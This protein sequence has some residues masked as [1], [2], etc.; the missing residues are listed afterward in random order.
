MALGFEAATHL[1]YASGRVF[2]STNLGAVA[3]LDAYSGSV[4]WLNIYRDAS[5]T[6][7]PNLMMVGPMARGFGGFPGGWGAGMPVQQNPPPLPSPW[8]ANAA[9]VHGGN[10][11]VLPTDGKY[12]LVYDAGNGRT[13]KKIKKSDCPPPSIDDDPADPSASEPN[14]LLGVMDQVPVNDH[15]TVR[16]E[17]LLLLGTPSH[18]VAINWRDYSL[19]Q[20]TPPPWVALNLN[21]GSIL[22]RAFL[23]SD[24]VYVPTSNTL[25]RVAIRTGTLVEAYP[26]GAAWPPNEEPGNV[27]VC[28]DQIVVAGQQRVSVYSDLKFAQSRLDAQIA[29]AP[30]D[31][32]LRLRYA[33]I[34]FLA[35]QPKLAAQKLDEAAGLLAGASGP[36]DR[37]VGNQAFSDAIEFAMKSWLGN[38]D[39]A[40]VGGLF[41]RAMTLAKTPSQQANYRL[42]R[43]RYEHFGAHDLSAAINLYQGILASDAQRT[44]AA[45]ESIIEDPLRASASDDNNALQNQAWQVAATAIA[46]IQSEP[47]G[48]EAYKPFEQAA[49]SQFDAA[50]KARDADAEI[51]VAREY[52]NASVSANGTALLAAAKL[53]D[54]MGRAADAARLWQELYSRANDRASQVAILQ[55]VARNELKLP[56]GLEAADS[57]LSAA[58]RLDPG[59]TL[60]APLILPGGQ[61][62][63]GTFEEARR[64]IDTLVKETAATSGGNLP[65]IGLPP[66]PVARAY[67]AA[68]QPIAP[69]LADD[70]ASDI[71][72]V[73]K[74]LMPAQLYARNDRLTA[75]TNGQGLSIY[76]V[77]KSAALGTDA[78]VADEPRGAAWVE[79]Y[80]NLLTW[81]KGSL[82]LVDGDQVKSRW[83]LDLA[84][85]G[86]L[87]V[88]AEPAPRQEA[89][90]INSPDRMM[91]RRMQ[92]S[93]LWVTPQFQLNLPDV[94]G[95]GSGLSDDT[96]DASA[97]TAGPESITQVVPVGDMALV[98]TSIGRVAAVKISDGSVVWQNRLADRAVSRL[99]AT[100]DFTVVLCG[101]DAAARLVVLNTT[102]GELIAHKVFTADSYPGQPADFPI[103]LALGADGTLAYTL[104]DRVVLCDL[105]EAGRDENGRESGL[106][107]VSPTP[108]LPGKPQLFEGMNKPGQ[109]VIHAGQVL[110]LAEGGRTL[111]GYTVDGA[112]FR[113]FEVTDDQKQVQ[114]VQMVLAAGDGDDQAQL[115][116]G[117]RYIYSWGSRWLTAYNLDNPETSWGP[118]EDLQPTPGSTGNLLLGRDYLVMLNQPPDAGAWRMW[119]FWRAP[120]PGKPTE[121]TGA[122]VYQMDLGDP[123]GIIAAEAVDG[124]V[125]YLDG[126]HT[127]HFLR[128]NRVPPALGA[129]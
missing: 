103:N 76:P 110:A 37:A 46:R 1:S 22:G 21:G 111:C 26:S 63:S 43:A 29:A 39:D 112:D 101:D 100:G 67:R 97:V 80:A 83:T 23:T 62:L 14:A 4:A 74:L 34:M 20:P 2:V 126:D 44:V 95:G 11:F 98:A 31:P 120:V 27:I 8:T 96:D 65:D 56:G 7:D 118:P 79:D 3:A 82:H 13:V 105:Y 121:E 41:D 125:V 70:T 17:D 28:G 77:G 92:R 16:K 106:D 108:E 128:G 19:D 129:N 60:A 59:A 114:S 52:P 117:G 104:E 66:R 91:M 48:A 36:A 124:G 58:I 78:S 122:L 12:I 127:L 93:Q 86:D 107:H 81:T 119:A 89:N 30:A 109:L 38:A 123:H 54:S 94:G 32:E 51:K 50:Q 6:A 25:D 113:R 33:E 72:G 9:I 10:V 116:I 45:A 71:S 64:A 73:D 68:H 53:Y 47:N 42:T 85:L 55:Y 49:A 18:I 61:K 88:M 35:D 84:S 90:L 57:R 102:T 5:D 40:Q 15:G 69:F 75:W 99:E 115:R 87:D 24:S